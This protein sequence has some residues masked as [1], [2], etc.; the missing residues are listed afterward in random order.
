MKTAMM[1]KNKPRYVFNKDLLRAIC[2]RL[3]AIFSKKETRTP[4]LYIIREEPAHDSKKLEGIR[5]ES[6]KLDMGKALMSK[7]PL[8][9][10]FI[11]SFYN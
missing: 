5:E 4:G 9:L 8:V 7:M 1:E 11:G 6:E 10:F 2:R 3:T